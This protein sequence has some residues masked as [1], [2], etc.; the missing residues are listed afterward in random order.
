MACVAGRAHALLKTAQP[1]AIG[2]GLAIIVNI[3]YVIVHV[4]ASGYLGCSVS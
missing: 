4:D 2:C 3:A 1:G